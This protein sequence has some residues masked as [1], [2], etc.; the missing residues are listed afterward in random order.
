MWHFRR[1]VIGKS[2]IPTTWVKHGLAGW[3][4]EILTARPY[5]NKFE[6]FEV[7][8]SVQWNGQDCWG[9]LKLIGQNYWNHLTKDLN[10]MAI[11]LGLISSFCHYLSTFEINLPFVLNLKRLKEKN[12]HSILYQIIFFLDQGLWI[13]LKPFCAILPACS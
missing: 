13:C 9:P 6:N 1:K 7:V 2:L 5:G 4:A 12:S 8:C 11:S 3:K 10:F